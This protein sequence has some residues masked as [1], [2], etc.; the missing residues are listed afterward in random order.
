VTVTLKLPATV[1]ALAE[2]RPASNTAVPQ[3][4]ERLIFFISFPILSKTAARHLVI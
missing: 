3:N 4:I 2:D 1:A